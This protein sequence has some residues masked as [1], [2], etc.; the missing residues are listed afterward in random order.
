MK[1]IIFILFV[2]INIF[3]YS[4]NIDD[5]VIMTEEY[6]PYNFIENGKIVGI[7]T[8]LM[9]EM[10]KKMD[11]KLSRKDIKL[12]PWIRG[13]VLT[14]DNKNR[15]LFSMTR[16]AEREKLFKWVGPIMKG[17]KNSLI[18]IKNKQLRI[19][20]IEDLKKYRIATIKEDE[21]ELL[22]KKKGLE[23]SIIPT[24]DILV[25]LKNL[26]LGRV[27]M[28]AYGLDEIKWVMK[29]NGYDVNNYESVFNLNE[30][31]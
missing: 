10:L 6:P 18:A 15:V 1:K 19:N 30:R 8:D 11:T 22:L 4:D 20:S 21:T 14:Q 25:N 28:I 13:Y 17:S 24:V 16:T 23:K 9:V 2:L 5:V 29:K 7:G 12:Y 27:D 3:V 31:W 26:E